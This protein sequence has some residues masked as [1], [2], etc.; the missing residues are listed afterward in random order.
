MSRISAFVAAVATELDDETVDFVIGKANEGK[1][2]QRRR[3]HW[4]RDGGEIEKTNRKGG[5]MTG[6]ETTRT[7]SVWTRQERIRVCVFAESETTIETLLDNLI[8]AID[9]TAGVSAF[10]QAAYIWH[11]NEIAQRVPMVELEFRLSLP[12]LDEIT[13]LVVID[14]VDTTVE[15]VES[16]DE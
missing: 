1:H 9:R 11:E 8:V 6:A 2:G 7:V 14:E 4:Y 16:L 5:T 15:F 12:V 13:T 10:T 3:V